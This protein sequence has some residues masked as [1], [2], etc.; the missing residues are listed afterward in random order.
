[1]EKETQMPLMFREKCE[2]CGLDDVRCMQ[3]T[4]WVGSEK[5]ICFICLTDYYHEYWE[6][7][8]Y[9]AT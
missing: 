5:A 1:M 3:V 7:K 4:S 6:D 9:R 2:Y 8:P